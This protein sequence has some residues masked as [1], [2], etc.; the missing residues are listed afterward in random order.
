MPLSMA[1]FGQEKTIIKITGSDHVKKH[2]ENLGFV[3]GAS[4]TIISELNGNMILKVKDA[5]IALDKTM[6]NRILV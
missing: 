2:L 5:R 6:V 1:P 4:V 3:I